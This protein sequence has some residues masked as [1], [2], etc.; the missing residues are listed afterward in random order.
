MKTK[1][2]ILI[3]D[4]CLNRNYKFKLS[5]N[6]T[7]RLELSKYCKHCQKTQIHKETR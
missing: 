5:N 1:N 6:R 7:Y 2:A 3:C 4:V